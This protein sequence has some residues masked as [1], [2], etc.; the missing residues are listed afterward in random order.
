M[1]EIKFRVW[2][3]TSGKGKMVS[4]EELKQFPVYAVFINAPLEVTMEQFTGLK[5]KNG[6]E[7]YEGDIL[8]GAIGAP[9]HWC[10]KR[11]GWA[12]IFDGECACYMCSGDTELSEYNLT[13]LEVIGNVHENPELITS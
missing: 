2:D 8:G 7:I 6:V 11:M 12:F 1:R 5:D 9:V 3:T 13:E 4:W 10:E